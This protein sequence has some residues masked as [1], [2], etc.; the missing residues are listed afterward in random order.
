MSGTVWYS[1][2]QLALHLNRKCSVILGQSIRY[3]KGVR[4]GFRY[5]AVQGHTTE[6]RYSNIVVVHCKI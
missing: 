4:V 3:K 5:R 6:G 2:E 1:R